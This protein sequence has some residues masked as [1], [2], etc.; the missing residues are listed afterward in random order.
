MDLNHGTDDNKPYPYL[1]AE[2]S[3][4]E[5]VATFEELLR[6]V[7]VGITNFGNTS[8]TNPTDQGKI[9]S[10]AS[11]LQEMLMSRRQHG[12]LSREEFAIVSMMSWF[13]M[14]VESNLPIIGDLRADAA[15]PEQRL[16]KIA[17]RVGLPAH[18][19]SKSYFDIAHSISKVLIVIETGALNSAA[20]A[21]AFF[22]PPASIP[23]GLTPLEP[24]MRQI[25]THWSA[26]TGRGPALFNPRS[27]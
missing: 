16:F 9:A 20:A 14:T 27:L 23:A 8:G 12:T 10:L 25:I 18:G 21:P 17:W 19:L 6:E 11:K 15:G 5:F 7:W 2:T 4:N 22:A 26:I 24:D 1:K 3:N 13:H